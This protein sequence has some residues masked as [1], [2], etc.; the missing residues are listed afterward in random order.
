M[1][2][3]VDTSL[4][5]LI[6]LDEEPE[7]TTLGSAKSGNYGHIGRPGQIGGSGKGVAG[8]EI[9]S[10][11]VSIYHTS[12]EEFASGK[13]EFDAYFGSEEFLKDF[14]HEF[15]EKT[16]ALA[17]PPHLPILDLNQDTPEARDFMA[18]MAERA[19]PN[20]KEWPA[21]LRR[22]DPN[23]IQDFDE[24]WTDKAHAL[25][26]LRKMPSFEGVKYQGEYIL[27]KETIT[28]LT[29]QQ[30][31]TAEAR[32]RALA[33]PKPTVVHAIA[34]RFVPKIQ[35]AVQYAFTKGRHAVRTSVLQA[36]TTQVQARAATADAVDVTAKALKKVLPK[37]LHECLVASGE[38]EV[39]QL[40]VMAF[41][42]NQPR[43][44]QGQ[45]TSG[46]GSGPITDSPAFKQWFGQSKVVDDDGD[47]LVVY[48][49]TTHNIKKFADAGD[50]RL[51]PEADRGAA[52]YFSDS[53]EDVSENYAGIGPDL[54]SRIEE[55]AD[56]I[57]NEKDDPSGE[58]DH[59]KS[60]AQAKAELIGSTGGLALPVYLSMENPYVVGRGSNPDHPVSETFLTH[61]LEYDDPKDPESDI[62]GATGTLVDLPTPCVMKRDMYQDTEGVDEFISNRS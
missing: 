40:R 58:Y 55:R 20:E 32:M 48:H 2:K 17:L 29:G 41:N 33:R 27:P 57:D 39:G 3:F 62:V 46:G 11:T 36:A 42:P 21:Q 54:T 12:G 26:A 60:V 14:P 19:Y 45:W 30:M 28:R 50:P 37:V 53:P 9:R 4:D 6:L 49:G 43:D 8:A 52:A 1:N 38:A 61:E 5:F 22:G 24:V 47:P 56:Q 44:E 51:N 18:T 15:G 23:A 10:H 16:Y 7:P 25:A 31:K 59:E 13:P 34:D 35:N